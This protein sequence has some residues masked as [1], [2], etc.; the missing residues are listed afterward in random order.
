MYKRIHIEEDPYLKKNYI[1]QD[2]DHHHTTKTNNNNISTKK[3]LNKNI[4][5]IYTRAV[6][7]RFLFFIFKS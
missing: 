6:N 3:K 5:N 1:I 7:W 4:Q 2:Q